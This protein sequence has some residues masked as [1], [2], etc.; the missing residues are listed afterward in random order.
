MSQTNTAD[1]LLQAARR[2]APDIIAT[3]DTID[4]E[5]RLPASL[6]DRLR[7]EGLFHLWLPSALGGPEL[8]PAQYIAII[9]ALATADG[10]VGWC[11]A[12]AGVF[13]LLAGS[14]PDATAH[15]IFGS[16]SV[17]AGS[18][19]PTGRA[20]AVAG[21]YRASG[22]WGYASGIDHASWSSV[23]KPSLQT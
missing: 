12:N 13:S 9:E 10:A 5:R 3:R 17:V 15:E 4:R 20:D 22:R 14:L 21:G 18:V 1:V 6:V 19:N 23:K 11:A 16:R 7:D 8:H 2:L